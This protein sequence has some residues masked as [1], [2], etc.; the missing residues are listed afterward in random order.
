MSNMVRTNVVI[1]EDL[2]NKV[3]RA[4]GLPSKR[5]TIEF[6]LRTLAG[7]DDPHA[8]MLALRGTGWQGDLDSMRRS[9]VLEALDAPA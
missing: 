2:I 6:A 9:P 1:D 5:A 8:G 3:M 7:A 4:Y